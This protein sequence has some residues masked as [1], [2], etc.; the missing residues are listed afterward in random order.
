VR[1]PRLTRR[2]RI[3]A[4]FDQGLTLQQIS[5]AEPSIRR[6]YIRDVLRFYRSSTRPS[7]QEQQA[8]CG[9]DEKHLWAIAEASDWR[10]FPYCAVRP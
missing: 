5:T 9:D 4:L 3:E 1:S 8:M 2:P 7:A 6:E 10:G